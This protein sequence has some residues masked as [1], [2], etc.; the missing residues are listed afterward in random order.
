MQIHFILLEPARGENVGAAARA[1]KTMG[2]SSLRVVA[3]EAHLDEKAKWTAHGAADILEQCQAFESLESALKDVDLVIATTAR[4]RGELNHYLT[5][6]QIGEQIQD[7][8]ESHQSIAILF[9]REASGLTNEELKMADLVTYLPLA[10]GY[11]SLNLGQAVMLYAY[12][13][14]K[15]NI[16]PQQQDQT[17]VNLAQISVLKKQAKALLHQVA[18][19]QDRK[20]EAW[21]LEGLPL[22]KQRDLNLLHTLINDI[23]KRL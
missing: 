6:E 16:Q 15:F 14:G 21:L 23:S 1:L 10:V 3:S 18:S 19:E 7:K 20:L 8:S 13:L 4:K 11:P 12:E 5:P 2:F 17:K 22:L 9:G